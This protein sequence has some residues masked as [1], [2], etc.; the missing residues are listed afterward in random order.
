MQS[1]FF[2]TSDKAS[3]TEALQARRAVVQSGSGHTGAHFFNV[4]VTGPPGTGKT[5]AAH[6]LGRV[7]FGLGLT[8][9]PLD[10]RFTTSPGTF[11]KGY[12]G[13]ATEAFQRVLEDAQRACAPVFIDEAYELFTSHEGSKLATVLLDFLG[14]PKMNETAAGGACRSIVMLAG[15]KDQM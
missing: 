10:M 4:I 13:Q 14:S 1:Y 7:F 8:A 3:T 5:V 2:L 6:I 12:E 11:T 9:A 15:Y